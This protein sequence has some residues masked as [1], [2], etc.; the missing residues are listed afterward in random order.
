MANIDPAQIDVLSNMAYVNGPPHEQLQWLRENQPMFHQKIDDPIMVGESYV[1]T[2]HAD[3]VQ[4]S[5]DLDHFGNFAGHNLRNDHNLD[6]ISHMLMA[7]RPRHTELRLMASRTFTPKVVKRY[8]AHYHHL[9]GTLLDRAVPEGTFDVVDKLAIEL[10]MQAI[11][12]LMGSSLD[13]TDR[14]LEWSNAT[15]SSLD[16]DYAPTADARDKALGEMAAY[17][18]ELA[19]DRTANPQDDV[20]TALVEHLN[21]GSLTELEYMGYVILV[22]VAGNETTRNNISWGIH[23]LATNPDQY[24]LLRSD[25]DRYL[26]GAVEEI[27]RWASPVNY[28]SRTVH[29]P[30]ELLGQEMNVGDKV[31][32]MYLS[33]NRDADVFVDPFRFDITRDPN[34]Q[35]AFGY[36]VHFCMGAHLARLETK[37]LLAELVKR[38]ERLEMAGEVEHTWSSFINGIK[39]LPITVH[40]G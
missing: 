30:T 22:F 24:A 32:L 7:D 2:R 37:A 21:D 8:T 31:A 6:A 10:P 28:M 40:K 29:Q 1:V 23:G 26:D 18:M 38:V 16:P 39:R 35:I 17:A 36:G 11:V 4:V 15:I 5:R 13:D 14:L 34:P 9:A 27:T 3:I 20:A 12:E 33:G 25:P 19:A